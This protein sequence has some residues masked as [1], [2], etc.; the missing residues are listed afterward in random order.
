MKPWRGPAAVGG[1]SVGSRKIDPRRIERLEAFERSLKVQDAKRRLWESYS[2][3]TDE[4]MARFSF[5]LAQMCEEEEGE[6]L[7][8]GGLASTEL[9]EERVRPGWQRFCETGGQAAMMDFFRATD[10]GS[11]KSLS[12]GRPYR[13]LYEGVSPVKK[14][15]EGIRFHIN[16]LGGRRGSKKKDLA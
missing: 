9:L 6:A 4:E 12:W 15:K 2:I 3:M 14:R 8:G 16:R 13:V 7:F 11:T 10:D 5:A 1:W